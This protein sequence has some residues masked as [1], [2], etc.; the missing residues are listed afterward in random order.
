MVV[1]LHL[2]A[3]TFWVGGML[4]LSLVAVPLLKGDRDVAETQRRF[5]SMA[6]RF[7]SLAWGAIVIL[8]LTGSILLP[9]H[10]PMTTPPD[11]WPTVILVKLLLVI[12]A[13]AVSST[14]EFF[15]GPKVSSIKQ[16]PFSSWSPTEQKLVTLS[17]WVSRLTLVLGLAI[18]LFA[19]VLSRH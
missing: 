2:L 19:V 13:I 1:W 4:F 7:R 8:L 15:F 3:A 14:H 9:R 10:V 11:E 12:F 17:P 6:R 16:K 18:I 5:L